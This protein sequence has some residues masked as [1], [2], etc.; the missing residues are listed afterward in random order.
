MLQLAPLTA[1][2]I[3]V[4]LAP[5]TAGTDSFLGV[6][7]AIRLLLFSPLLLQAAVP[8]SF[9]GRSAKARDVYTAYYGSFMF[10]G[11][12]SALLIVVQ[13]AM[14]FRET[15]FDPSKVLRS[16][17]DSPAVS[18]LGYDYLFSLVSAGVWARIVGS[19]LA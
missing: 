12:C 9:G 2:Y 19:D 1:Y 14:A 18:A 16:I 13:T 7:G 17:N 6:V 11:A 4:V 10:M 15:A 5:Y 8:G 3:F